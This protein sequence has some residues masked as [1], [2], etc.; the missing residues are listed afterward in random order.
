MGFWDLE[1]R[2]EGLVGLKWRCISHDGEAYVS[3]AASGV[4]DHPNGATH[5]RP[6]GAT[7]NAVFA[8]IEPAQK[9]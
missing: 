6:E 2:G 9:V 8:Y 1:C 3:M 4:T 5:V 7:G